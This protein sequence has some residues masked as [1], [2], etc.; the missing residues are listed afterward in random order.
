MKKII[1]GI[2]TFTLL[3]FFSACTNPATVL[4]FQKGE[5]NYTLT[6]VSQVGSLSPSTTNSSGKIIFQDDNTG[7]MTPSSA[8]SG[9]NFSW[10]YDKSGNKISITDKNNAVTI[11][12]VTEKKFSSEK[13]HNV[14]SST[15]LGV[16]YTVTTDITLSR[17]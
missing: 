7:T 4:P 8:T 3:A 14:S 16:T 2:F 12:D 5:W 9:D 6:A 1:F 15:V 10:S 13:W 17:K 11:Y